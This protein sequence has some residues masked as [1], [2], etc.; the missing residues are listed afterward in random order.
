[1]LAVKVY[2][3]NA[4]GIPERWPAEVRELREGEPLPRGFSP[5]TPREYEALRASLAGEMEAFQRGRALTAARE[6]RKTA[7]VDDARRFLVE[8]WPLGG[9]A[10]VARVAGVSL[11]PRF[12]LPSAST[13]EQLAQQLEDALGRIASAGSVAEVEAVVLRLEEVQR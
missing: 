6:R 4:D 2:G 5:M 8:G 10:L 11:P 9:W 7:V 13:C 1:V 12:V 3:P